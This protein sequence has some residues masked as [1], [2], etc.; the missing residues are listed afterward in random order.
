MAVYFVTG[1]LGAGKSI[2]AV[3]MA[4]RYMRRDSPVATNFDLFLDKMD[5]VT[6]SHVYRLPD[7]PRSI[8]F[9]ALGRGAAQDEKQKLGA[10][11]LDECA[12]WLNSR[13]FRDPDRM[14]IIDWCLH[15]RKH[16]WDVYFLV[17]DMDAVDKQ[18][19]DALCQFHVR[20]E[21]MSAWRIPGLS[22]IYDLYRAFKTKGEE[23]QSKILPHINKAST[24]RGQRTDLKGNSNGSEIYFPK[25]FYG[26]Y[27]TNQIF[28]DGKEMIGGKMVDMR[29]VYSVLTP[30]QLR[31][32]ADKPVPEKDTAPRSGFKPLRFS[33]FLASVLG[34]IWFFFSG[35]T[36]SA[37]SVPAVTQVVSAS[38]VPDTV[39]VTQS[40]DPESSVPP[41]P[42][43]ADLLITG[44][45]TIHHSDGAVIYDYAL[46]TLDN[47]PFY[48]DHSNAVIAGV[49]ACEAQIKM[50]DG[51]ILRARCPV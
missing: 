2:Y 19:R 33:F 44:F 50:P 25:P 32:G 18:V 4:L 20:C 47:K 23:Q 45:V 24:Y 16:G 26:M 14:P 10:I 22:A 13:D 41:A 48:P 39:A 12:T 28:H 42:P 37:E 9:K 21:D 43:V 7:H 30:R 6:K 11:F 29:A 46:E 38:P 5:T 31:G 51:R 49:N 40:V 8:D 36:D 27:D 17:Q 1:S 35:N 34:A 15:A 3:R